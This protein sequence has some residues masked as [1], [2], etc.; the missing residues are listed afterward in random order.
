LQAFIAEPVALRAAISS[1]PLHRQVAERAVAL[2]LDGLVV[3]SQGA[4]AE[5]MAAAAAPLSR[6]AAAR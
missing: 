4:E 3:V 6:L 2:G 1:V 5:A